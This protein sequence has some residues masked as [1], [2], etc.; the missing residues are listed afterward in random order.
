MR[1]VKEVLRKWHPFVLG[2]ALITA[3]VT[4]SATLIAHQMQ[5]DDM[6]ARDVDLQAHRVKVGPSGPPGR[7]GPPGPPGPTGP[8]GKHGR[9]GRHGRDGREG[10]DGPDGM[11][12][13]EGTDG[14][15]GV[16]V[17]TTAPHRTMRRAEA[18]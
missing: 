13:H 1:S 14:R 18:P 10:E 3:I 11:M 16:V 15:K 9:N 6:R 12:G 5:I 2:A 8:Q 4:Q 7:S 17:A